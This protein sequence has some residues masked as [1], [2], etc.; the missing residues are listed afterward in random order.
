V[1]EEFVQFLPEAFEKEALRERLFVQE[2]TPDVLFHAFFDKAAGVP[3]YLQH[4]HRLDQ[5]ERVLEPR[6]GADDLNF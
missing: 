4:S 2:K 1:R 5:G 3:F 6:L